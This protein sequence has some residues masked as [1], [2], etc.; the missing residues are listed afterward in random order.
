MLSHDISPRRAESMKLRLSGDN[1]Y[2]ILVS[3]Q[4][5]AFTSICPQTNN[6]TSTDPF[7]N[8][9][10]T[11]H[12]LYHHVKLVPQRYLS[13]GGFFFWFG[14]WVALECRV[15]EAR[16]PRT[17]GYHNTGSIRGSPIH[18]R[19]ITHTFHICILPNLI[20]T[21]SYLIWTPLVETNSANPAWS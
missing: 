13:R 14:Y 8:T 7:Y 16:V 15:R 19:A 21:G 4:V 2:I 10:H 11:C 17:W 18:I 5:C 12:P 20:N 1:Q 3:K 9:L 6:W